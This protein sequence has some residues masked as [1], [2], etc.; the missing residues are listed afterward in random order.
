M[1]PPFPILYEDNHL[2]VVEKPVNVPVQADV[3]GDD[4][5]LSMCRRYIKAAY[6]KPGEAFL[7]LV[8]RLDRPVGGVMVFARTSKAAAR[9]TAQFKGR[10]AKKRYA[11]VVVGCPPAEKRLV[12]FLLKD[13]RTHSSAVVP[14]GTDGA[15]RA[16]LCYRKLAACGDRALLDIELFT[17]RPH[18]IRVQLAHDG[19]PILGDQRYNPAARPGMQICLWAYALTIQHPTLGEE[20]TFFSL[21]GGSPNRGAAVEERQ[22]ACTSAPIERRMD[23]A[24]GSPDDMQ[25][26]CTGAATGQKRTCASGSPIERQMDCFGDS[27]AQQRSD[28]T[29]DSPDDMQADCTGAATGQK[30]AC[31]GGAPIERQMDCFGGSPDGRSGFAAFPVQTALLPAFGVCRGVAMDD[32]LLVVD[33]NAGVEVEQD[34]VPALESV[35]GPVYPVHRLDANTEGLVALA[36]TEAMRE[37]LL[38]AFRT[39]ENIEKIYHAVV[40]GTPAQRA[41]MLEHTLQKDAAGA[42][43]RVVAPGTPGGQPAKLAYRVLETRGGL[44][45]VEIE[46]Y[47]GRT[48][49]IR[50]QMAAIGCPVLGDDKYG[51]REMNRRC[52]VKR[53]QLLAKRLTIGGRTFES[54]RSFSF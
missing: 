16:E 27:A 30:R 42:F 12:D 24:A 20:M 2:L 21:P 33:K 6:N 9:L 10:T 8:H 37:Q 7:A 3:T 32:A 41:G 51:D 17:G 31:A 50:V 43:V 53:Q 44:S 25:T 40:V 46:L 26:D 52:R 15:K 4:D 39:H 36:R 28:C 35:I 19:F 11:A 38:R 47:T 34:L 23:C 18:Q 49:Q 5:L 45:L 48:H 22:T 14:E 1:T 29:G 54:L 13:E